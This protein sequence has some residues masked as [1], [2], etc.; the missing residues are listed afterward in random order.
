M[1]IF[2]CVCY[3]LASKYVTKVEAETIEEARI[4]AEDEAI[5]NMGYDVEVEEV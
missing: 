1:K 3:P 2:K 4:I 5:Q